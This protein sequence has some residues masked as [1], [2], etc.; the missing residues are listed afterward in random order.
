MKK[1]I[2]LFVFCMIMYH[3]NSQTI[4]KWKISE[5]EK[6]INS[7]EFE[8]VVINFWAT[9]CQPCVAEIPSFIAITKKIGAPKVKLILVSLDLPSY[10]PSKIMSFVKKRHFQTDIVWLDESNA[11]YFCPKIDKSWSG[12]IPSTLIVNTKTGYRKFFEEEMDPSTF[13]LE[14]NKAIGGENASSHTE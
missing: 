11:D 2:S 9:F 3:V 8:V 13:E 14:L 7:K 10:Y 5:V 1:C 6:C 12:S 4:P